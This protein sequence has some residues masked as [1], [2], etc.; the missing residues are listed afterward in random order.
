MS[1]DLHVYGSTDPIYFKLVDSSGVGVN[2]TLAAGDI[3]ISKDGGTPAN[4]SSLPT[5][6]D[7]TNMPGV[8]TWTPTAAEAQCKVM[9]INCKDVAG[10]AWVENCIIVSTGGNASARFSG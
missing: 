1:I 6:I 3:K 9:I 5:A 8:Y 4:V 2:D 7:G 10:A